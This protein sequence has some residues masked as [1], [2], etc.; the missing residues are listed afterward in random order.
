MNFKVTKKKSS[1]AKNLIHIQENLLRFDKDIGSKE[2]YRNTDFLTRK[3]NIVNTLK[4]INRVNVLRK[5]AP[6]IDIY[7]TTFSEE[8]FKKYSLKIT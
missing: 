4:K 7:K 1:L 6:I 5:N 3:K 8:F 2:I